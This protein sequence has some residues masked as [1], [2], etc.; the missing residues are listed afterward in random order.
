MLQGRECWVLNKLLRR[1]LIE[2]E[3]KELV[4]WLSGGG[5]FQVEGNACAKTLRWELVWHIQGTVR[6][7]IWQECSK[8][9]VRQYEMGSRGNEC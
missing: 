7:P 9:E 2:K 8:A 4:I 3:V 5:L 6:R 1:D